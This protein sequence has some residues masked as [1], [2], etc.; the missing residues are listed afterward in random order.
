MALTTPAVTVCSKPSG[1]PMA[2]ASWPGLMVFES[3]RTSDGADEMAVGADH[4]DI[5]IRIFAD[6]ARRRP[7]AVRQRRPRSPWRH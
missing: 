6:D 3:C 1:L 2:I 4:R 7:L 5:G